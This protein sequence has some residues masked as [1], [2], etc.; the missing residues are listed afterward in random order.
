[1]RKWI[2]TIAVILLL[3]VAAAPMQALAAGDSVQA[4][5][6]F[7]V[8][9]AP[10][11]VVIE[12]VTPGAP[13]PVP[14]IYPDF[15][16]EGKFE[17][18]FTEPGNYAYKV[19]EQ[20]GAEGK[21][22][23]DPTVFDVVVYVEYGQTGALR[24]TVVASEDD[25]DTKPGKVKFTNPPPTTLSVT[26]VAKR[27]D[28]IAE[29]VFA[30]EEIVYEIAV[31]NT[32]KAAAYK[33]TVTDTLPIQKPAL[34]VSA[35]DDGGALMQ[36]D[37]IVQWVI[38]KLEAGETATV[39]FTVTIP[40]ISNGVK[41]ENNVQVTYEDRADPSVPW[42][43]ARWDIWEEPPHVDIVKEQARND[44]SRTKDELTV[45]EGDRI[46]YY[47]IVTN[48]GLGTAKDVVIKDMIP[49]GLSLTTGFISHSGTVSDGTITWKLGDLA[50]GE[51]VTLSF[52]VTVPGVTEKTT[53]ANQGAGV[54][55]DGSRETSD[56]LLGSK[57]QEVTITSNIV[58][59][60]GYPN[61]T[62]TS[63]GG[64]DNTDSSDGNDTTGGSSSSGGSGGSGSSGSS[65]STGGTSGTT[66]GTTPKTGDERQIKLWLALLGV[67]LIGIIVVVIVLVRR[68]KK[69]R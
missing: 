42:P 15:A 9:K 58:V 37:K 17:I 14:A 2:R 67:S 28:E 48:S 34:K 40:T 32:G 18:T 53:W 49:K 44:G 59:S 21:E 26:K 65:D 36:D 8:N 1:M 63:G 33:V 55:I 41:W 61:D 54:Y 23:Y 25:V 27:G 10:G 64:D 39:H 29:E 46:T 12:A 56:S 69:N 6:P 3:I 5:I 4:E 50:P 51:S 31:T 22:F 38:E 35:I 45:E 11:T 13:M 24:C 60:E 66:S 52:V 20:E 47:L 43:T 57:S 7:A 68:N 30:Y 62:N 16:G 19:Y